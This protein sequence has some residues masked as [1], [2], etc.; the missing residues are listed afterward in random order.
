MYNV[1][2]FALLFLTLTFGN[3]KKVAVLPTFSNTIT[4]LIFL[5]ELSDTITI[6]DTIICQNPNKCFLMFIVISM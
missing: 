6:H 1:F 4:D 3:Y 2:I 5:S